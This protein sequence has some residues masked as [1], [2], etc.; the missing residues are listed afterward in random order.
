MDYGYSDLNIWQNINAVNLSL[1]EKDWQYCSKWK[2]LNFKTKIR[3]AENLYLS[4]W[5]A[6]QHSKS[7]LKRSLSSVQFSLSVVPDSLWPP[8]LEDA[9]LPC[10]SPTP[11]VYS[12]SCPSSQW[13]HPTISS[14]VVPFSSCLQSFQHQGLFQWVSSSHQVTKGL[15]LQL[16]HQSFQWIFRIDLI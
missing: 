11:G 10:P 2:N 1:K 7:F 16:Q 9:R 3:I 15:E 5:H 14:S 6:S 8:G 13:C 4:L 12:N